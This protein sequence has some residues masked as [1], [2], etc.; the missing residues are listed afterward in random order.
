MYEKSGSF[1]YFKNWISFEH[2]C[3]QVLPERGQGALNWPSWVCGAAKRS[4]FHQRALWNGRDGSP[5]VRLQVWPGLGGY[6]ERLLCD[7]SGVHGTRYSERTADGHKGEA[8]GNKLLLHH[9]HGSESL[10]LN[11]TC[12]KNLIFYFLGLIIFFNVYC[13]RSLSY[14]GQILA[15]FWE[16]NNFLSN[17]VN[18][19]REATTRNHSFS[20]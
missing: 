1:I 11:K 3:L 16:I 18:E 7:T 2:L 19:S 5:W 9:P 6:E 12:I 4:H 10:K 13:V 14:F 8:L 17:S 15:L 20:A